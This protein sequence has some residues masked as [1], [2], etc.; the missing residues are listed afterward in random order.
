[1][2]TNYSPRI[3]RDGLLLYLDAGN[4]KSYPGSG[5][6]WYDLSPIKNNGIFTNGPIYS[7]LGG[8]SIE[9]DGSN[10]FID[11]NK[12]YIGTGEIE[13]GQANGNYTLEAWINVRSSQGTTT[14]A[15]S[16]IGNTS[17]YGVGMQVGIS[18]SSPRIN[19]GGRSTNNFYSSTFSYNTWVHVCLSRVGGSS[20]RTYLNGEFDVSTSASSLEVASG[21]SY[22][23]MRIGNSSGRV[24]G[25]YDGYIALVKI[26][27]I[28]LTDSQVAQNFTATRGR[29]GI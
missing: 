24:T 17:T 19:Y 22:T 7:S 21:Q 9:F 2:A 15:D 29:F 23:E 16:I 12:T 18:G 4:T 1:M 28:G 25:Y 3:V 11:L 14:D 20:V 6:T 27:N 26:Y 10:D 5:T 13:T 8:G